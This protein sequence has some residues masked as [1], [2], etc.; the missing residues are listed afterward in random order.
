MKAIVLRG[1]GPEAFRLDE[2]PMPEPGKGEIRVRVTACGVNG[3]D[4]EFAVGRPIYGR[5]ARVMMRVR[6]PG[7]D[8]V[9][10]V[11]AVGEGV[12]ALAPGDRV[13]GDVFEV[14]GGLAE[15]CVAP[16]K[17]FVPV[18]DALED[19]TA[20][21]LPQSG[22]IAVQAFEGKLRPGQKALVNGGGGGAGPLAIQMAKAE[23]A[24]VWA[25]DT[26]AKADAMRRA[27]ADHVLDYRQEDFAELPQRFDR[28]LDLYA[29]RPMAKVA[30]CLTEDGQYQL[31]GGHMG[32]LLSALLPPKRTGILM[33]KQGPEATARAFELARQGILTPIIGETAPLAHA[34]EALARMGRGE[35]GGKLV[36]T[37]G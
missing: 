19:A 5:I 25:V 17:L 28:I 14:F 32:L 2:R 37:M 12:T 18:P 26:A 10:V 3:A 1:W 9:G 31:V 4:W 22:A 30:G 15:F 27:G 8:V 21:A 6:V 35:I 20:A 29:T 24:E 36:I 23:G 33:V 7:S 16:A 13:A 34:P 11:D